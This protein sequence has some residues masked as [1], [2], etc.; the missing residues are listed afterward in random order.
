MVYS[1]SSGNGSRSRGSVPKKSRSGETLSAIAASVSH[2]GSSAPI[3]GPPAALGSPLVRRDSKFR[4]LLP[5]VLP[6][7]GLA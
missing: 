6:G 3:A 1:R 4:Q 5:V 2:A 7:G